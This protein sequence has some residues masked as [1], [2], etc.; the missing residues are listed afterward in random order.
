MGVKT[1]LLV[2]DWT[3]HDSD[4]AICVVTSNHMCT[5]QCSTPQPFTMRC[6][7]TFSETTNHGSLYFRAL[8]RL[9]PLNKL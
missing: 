1:T 2:G 5:L 4:A 7:L 9:H 6:F 3:E 8:L